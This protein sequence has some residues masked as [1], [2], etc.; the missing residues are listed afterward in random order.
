[1]ASFRQHS[2]DQSLF[3]SNLVRS[4]FHPTAGLISSGFLTDYTRI[5]REYNKSLSF[6]NQRPCLYT[7]SSSLSPS[8]SFFLPSTNSGQTPPLCCS[9]PPRMPRRQQVLNKGVLEWNKR[10]MTHGKDLVELTI[11]QEKKG[12]KA[13]LQCT[14]NVRT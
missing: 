12:L 14:A 8:R 5:N 3:F 4:P 10:Q 9:V 2:W 1:M 13:P 7:L 11:Y 6:K